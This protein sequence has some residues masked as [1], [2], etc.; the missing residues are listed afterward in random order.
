M[1]PALAREERAACRHGVEVLPRPPPHWVGCAALGAAG[2]RHATGAAPEAASQP[3]GDTA[4]VS[5]LV[6][7]PVPFQ[8]LRSEEEGVQQGQ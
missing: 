1:E 8:G 4:A 5:W 3:L 2:L 7:R 6:Q